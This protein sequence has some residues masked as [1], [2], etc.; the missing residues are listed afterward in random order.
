MRRATRIHRVVLCA[1]AA[2]AFGCSEGVK[3]FLF[4]PSDTPPPPL[5]T[6][7]VPGPSPSP[8]EPVPT[9]TPYPTPPP[10]T[11]EDIPDNDSPV[12]KVG[13]K[14]FFIECDG[15]IVPGSENTAEAP[16]GCRLHMDCTA[17]DEANNPT[18]AQGTPQWSLSNPQLVSGGRLSGDYTPTFDIRQEGTLTLNVLID[19][20][21]SNDVTIRFHR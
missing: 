10:D 6:A 15:A 1:A 20:V 8:V 16:V 14:V 9:P 21:R 19:G 18:R 12:A 17:K 13:A 3:E 2:G 5:Q 7:S 4:G 11:G